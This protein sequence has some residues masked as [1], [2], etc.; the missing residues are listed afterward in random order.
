VAFDVSYF[1]FSGMTAILDTHIHRLDVIK[2]SKKNARNKD[3]SLQ[4][5]ILSLKLQPG[6]ALHTGYIMIRGIYLICQ[7]RIPVLDFMMENDGSFC[8]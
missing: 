7:T 1:M 8:L 4:G 5:V 3:N 6:L 2:N